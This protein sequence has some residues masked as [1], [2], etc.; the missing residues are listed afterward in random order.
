[1]RWPLDGFRSIY[2]DQLETFENIAERDFLSQAEIRA[3]K[4]P[5]AVL[6]SGGELRPTGENRYSIAAW[7]PFLTLRSKGNLNRIE[8]SRRVF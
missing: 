7:D 2:L 4:N 1:M 5:S 8:T 3:S 6:L